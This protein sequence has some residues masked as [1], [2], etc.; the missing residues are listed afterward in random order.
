MIDKIKALVAKGP[1]PL[2][3]GIALVLLPGGF[4]LLGL[5]YFFKKR[6]SQ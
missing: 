2:I 6:K 5:W 3:L 1:K 4:V